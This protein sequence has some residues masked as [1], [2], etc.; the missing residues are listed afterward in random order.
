MKALLIMPL[1]EISQHLAMKL[2]VE[3]G[4]RGFDALS[5]PNY[6]DYL[7]TV[8]LAPNLDVGIFMALSSIKEFIEDKQDYLIIGNCNH[9]I[10]FDVILNV[11][12]YH[13]EGEV[14]EDLELQ[15]LQANYGKDPELGAI[16]NHLY[17]TSDAEYTAGGEAADIIQLVTK[18]CQAKLN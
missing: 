6:A 1:A 10:P 12:P 2:M 14:V 4:K 5:V 15:Q 3:G 13:E 16:I 11:N 9:N 18:L 8:G 7:F 17:K